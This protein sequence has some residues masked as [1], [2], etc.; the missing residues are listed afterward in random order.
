MPASQNLCLQ[1]KTVCQQSAVIPAGM[2][3]G[4]PAGK[5]SHKNP[6]H[7]IVTIITVKTN[8]LAAKASALGASANIGNV[9]PFR[10]SM[11]LVTPD[12]MLAYGLDLVGFDHRR[13]GRVKR[14]T[15]VAR[16][17]EHYGSTPLVVSAIWESLQTTQLPRARIQ[18]KRWK[19]L[20]HFF[21]ALHW[22]K[23]YPTEGVRSGRFNFCEKTCQ[24]W[25]WLYMKKIAALKD[26]VVCIG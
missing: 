11:L 8:E 10:S 23:C 2:P 6:T 1:A 17:G 18:V 3:A 5:C 24:K 19:D 4:M 13:Q 26:Q 16:F 20:T 9:L 14:E 12:D 22:A 7:K 21:Q 15:N 25:G